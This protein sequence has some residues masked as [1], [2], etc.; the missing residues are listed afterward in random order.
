MFDTFPAAPTKSK[1][2]AMALYLDI[3]GFG[4]FMP[5]EMRDTL[6]QSIHDESSS[7]YCDETHSPTSLG[8]RTVRSDSAADGDSN[9]AANAMGGFAASTLSKKSDEVNDAMLDCRD[10]M[11]QLYKTANR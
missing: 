5:Q 3:C 11:T 10:E 8:T 1:L 7:S 9:E 4:P 2:V 6:Q